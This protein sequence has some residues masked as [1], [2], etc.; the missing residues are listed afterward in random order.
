MAI[1]NG[2]ITVALQKS[3]RLNE[4]TARLLKECD[5]DVPQGGRQD[6]GYSR[7]FPLKFLYVRNGDIPSIVSGGYADLGV[8]GEDVVLETGAPLIEAIKLP[9]G[10]CNLALGVR[11]DF[12]YRQVADLKGMQI[13]TS[14]PR[15][16]ENFFRF[17][18]VKDVGIL[19]LGGSV[20]LAANQ[21]WVKACVD[22]TSSGES[23]RVNG[24]EVRETLL[25]SQAEIVVSKKLRERPNSEDTVMDLF[26]RIVAV[27][28]AQQNRF[29]AV[30]APKEQV[31]NITE[32]AREAGSTSPNI[33]LSV[34]DN[35]VE[36]QAM[37]GAKSFWTTTRK[38]LA[39]GGRELAELSIVRSLPNLDDTEI[40]GIRQ[41]IY[42]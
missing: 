4:D 5:I 34:N 13:A 19:E 2:L 1:E 30:N 11:S 3:G 21:D 18:G 20:E 27:T 28:R 7:R 10:G 12:P 9:F 35:V 17:N 36:I 39:A 16:T 6:V 23:M 33:N 29:I 22:I 32:I 15:L 37:I 8:T 42:G 14:F 24:L 25:S 38:I 41:K 26:G 40:N 31:Q